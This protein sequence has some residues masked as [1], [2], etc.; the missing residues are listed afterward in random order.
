MWLNQETKF[1]ILSLIPFMGFP[2]E[3]IKDLIETDEAEKWIWRFWGESGIGWDF[4]GGKYLPL[5]IFIITISLFE[6]EIRFNSTR[7]YY[8]SFLKWHQKFVMGK[9]GNWTA[10]I[11][12]SS[13]VFAIYLV[14]FSD[15]HHCMA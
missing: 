8:A 15:M 1:Y 3:L 2:N 13:L 10:Y 4:F 14:H 9:S 6:Q 5:W 11:A 7:L 12:K